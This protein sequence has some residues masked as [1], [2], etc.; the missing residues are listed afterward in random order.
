VQRNQPNKFLKK[1]CVLSLRLV[2][3]TILA[4]AAAF[5]QEESDYD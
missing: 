2:Y 1:H 3:G 5:S 4:Y